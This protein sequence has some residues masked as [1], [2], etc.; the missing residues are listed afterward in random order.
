M[1]FLSA[2]PANRSRNPFTSLVDGFFS[3]SLP[4]LFETGNL[5]RTNVAESEDAYT[6][7]LELPGIPEDA[8][9]VKV[10]EGQ[11]LVQA[12]RKDE[13]QSQGRTWHRIEHRYGTF[14]RT[15]A[16]PKD[17]KADAIE[18]VYQQGVLTLTI[19]KVPAA[20]PV[21]IQVKAK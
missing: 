9:E 13:T 4:E 18:A 21:Q 15:V 6:V 12:E 2:V 3:D 11:L 16:L 1:R 5:P 8:I 7:Q 20:K 19:P 14:A 17:A 10:H